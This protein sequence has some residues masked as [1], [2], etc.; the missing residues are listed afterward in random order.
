MNLK[1]LL[2][3]GQNFIALL[4]QYRIEAEDLII[5]DEDVMFSDQASQ[6]REVI[7]ETVC[8]EGR[9]SEG[10]ITLFGTLHYNLLNKL[11]VFEMQSSEKVSLVN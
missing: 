11:A 2:L 1:E 9:N 8:M 4:N 6:K 10:L 3:K 5:K 7:K